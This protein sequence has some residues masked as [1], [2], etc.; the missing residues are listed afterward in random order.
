MKDQYARDSRVNAIS[1]RLFVLEERVARLERGNEIRDIPF[2]D[3]KI[4]LKEAILM[5]ARHLGARFD[6][7]PEEWKITVVPKPADSEVY[8]K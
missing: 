4:T 3:K 2:Q 7:T 6:Y 5:L 1:D 8:K